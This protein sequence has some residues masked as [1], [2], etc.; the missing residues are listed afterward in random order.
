MKDGFGHS[1]YFYA[2]S[3]GDQEMLK[4][5]REDPRLKISTITE[6]MKQCPM[7]DS[8]EEEFNIPVP[9]KRKNKKSNIEIDIIQIDFDSR[10]DDD[11]I[12]KFL[13]DFVR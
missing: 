1:A 3:R 11:Q 4:L 7:E 6:A 10:M 12:E 2:M 5:L 13:S 9:T 8:V